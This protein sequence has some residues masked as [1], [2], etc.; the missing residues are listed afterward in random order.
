MILFLIS[1]CTLFTFLMESMVK[2]EWVLHKSLLWQETSI[3]SAGHYYA[4]L[5]LL[6]SERFALCPFSFAS[7]FSL[8]S[9]KRNEAHIREHLSLCP[10]HPRVRM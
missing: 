9:K 8:F 2:A 7:T 1:I 4:T 6:L 3:S 5:H 10:S